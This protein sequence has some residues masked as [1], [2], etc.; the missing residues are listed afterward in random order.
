MQEIKQLALSF[1]P[2]NRLKAFGALE[3]KNTK[4]EIFFK[5]NYSRFYYFALQMVSEKE[6]CRD[7][8]SDA[9]EQTWLFSQKNPNLNQTSYMYSLVRN[10]CVDYIRHE[11][12]KAHYADFYMHM[13]NESDENDTSKEMEEQISQI[14]RIFQKLTPRTRTILKMCY[15]QKKTYNETAE[16]LGISVSAVRKHIVNA[17]KFF[18][19]EIVNEDK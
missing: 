19:L 4:F 12:A 8:V 14:Y 2:F 3:N 11:T 7:I 10:K 5:E 17:L 16:E 9:F 1:Y 13:F 18:R 15:F 6:V